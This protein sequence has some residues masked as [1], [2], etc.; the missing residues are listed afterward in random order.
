MSAWIR[1]GGTY[2]GNVWR[3][4]CATIRQSNR[5]GRYQVT[6][7]DTGMRT[8]RTLAEA[9]AAVELALSERERTT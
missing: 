2:G 7:V 1:I 5:I 8:Y 4:G 3:K 9:K 6:G